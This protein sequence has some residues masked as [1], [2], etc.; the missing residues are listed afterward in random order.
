M[1][2]NDGG[3]ETGAIKLAQSHLWFYKGRACFPIQW[4]ALIVADWADGISS[5]GETVGFLGAPQAHGFI[6]ISRFKSKR[7]IRTFDGSLCKVA[8]SSPQECSLMNSPGKLKLAL[9]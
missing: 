6:A 5:S 8:N 7:L 3:S 9:P 4:T 2:V 1:P